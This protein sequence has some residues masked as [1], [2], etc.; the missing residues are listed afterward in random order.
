MTTLNALGSVPILEIDASFPK[1]ISRMESGIMSQMVSDE[2]AK[3]GTLPA[4]G[5]LV[6]INES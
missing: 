5:E 2:V 4:G 1:V 3:H 6:D